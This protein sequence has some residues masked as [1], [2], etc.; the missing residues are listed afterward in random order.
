MTILRSSYDYGLTLVLLVALV[1]NVQKPEHSEDPFEPEDLSAFSSDQIRRSELGRLERVHGL[2]LRWSQMQR[3][4]RCRDW[5]RESAKGSHS[6]FRKHG[7]RS[8]GFTE[9][10]SFRHDGQ[11]FRKFW[12]IVHE[13]CEGFLNLGLEQLFEQHIRT[14]GRRASWFPTTFSGVSDG[15]GEDVS[16]IKNCLLFFK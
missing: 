5:L 15:C 14:A 7:I 12:K 2:R 8:Y 9:V 3:F 4:C 11:H 10:I 6:V 16:V 13:S 1:K